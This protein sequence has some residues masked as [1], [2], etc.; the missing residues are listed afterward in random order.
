MTATIPARP[1]EETNSIYGNIRKTY[2]IIYGDHPIGSERVTDA[3]HADEITLDELAG[4][5]LRLIAEDVASGVMP[6]DIYDFSELH[7]F[8]DA[9][10]YLLAT[11]GLDM[12]EAGN[13]LANAIADRV[14]DWLAG[15]RPWSVEHF[16]SEWHSNRQYA[17]KHHAEDKRWYL[18]TMGVTG[19]SGAEVVI[20]D[21]AS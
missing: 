20:A 6:W 19:A 2:G 12:T 9:N 8:V 11:V 16:D 5:V 3:Y 10:E 21:A 13:A 4:E 1:L 14:N 7:N 17:G 15:N 18:R